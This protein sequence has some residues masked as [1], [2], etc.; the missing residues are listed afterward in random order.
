MMTGSVTA[1]STRAT[2][3][4]IDR[5]Y[6]QLQRL[7]KLVAQAESADQ[8]RRCFARR[9]PASREVRKSHEP[10]IADGLVKTGDSADGRR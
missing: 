1:P 4:N 3:I 2:S 10:H 6:R 5:T 9:I 7:R 8:A